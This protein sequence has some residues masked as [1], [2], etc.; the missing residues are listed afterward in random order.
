MS[1]HGG[2]WGVPAEDAQFQQERPK[3][4]HGRNFVKKLPQ[5]LLVGLKRCVLEFSTIY[6]QNQALKIFRR[7]YG[8]LGVFDLATRRS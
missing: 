7:S 6:T 3:N 5:M 2:F 8:D 1:G 4:A